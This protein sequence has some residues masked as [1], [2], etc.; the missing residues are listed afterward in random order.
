MA[1]NQHP[2]NTTMINEGVTVPPSGIIGTGGGSLFVIAQ[3]V[4]YTGEGML[5][6]IE[7][8]IEFFLGGRGSLFEIE[9]TV[10]GY[11]VGKLFDIQQTIFSETVY[12]YIALAG[13]YPYIAIDGIIIPAEQITGE[14][15]VT[16]KENESTQ[17]TFTL[18]NPLGVQNLEQY[19]GKA[20]NIVFIYPTTAELVF[21]G[22]VNVITRDFVKKRSTY[23]CSNM[24]REAIINQLGPFVSTIGYYDANVMGAVTDVADE[25]EKR[26]STTTQCVDLDRSG[27]VNIHDMMPKTSPD[28][29]FSSGGLYRDVYPTVDLR[30]RSRVVNSITIKLTYQYVRLYQREINYIWDANYPSVCDFLQQGYSVAAKSTIEAAIQ[31]TGWPLRQIAYEPVLEGGWYNCDGVSMGWV[32]GNFNAG[33]VVRQTDDEGN[34]IEDASGNSIAENITPGSNISSQNYAFGASWIAATRFSQNRQEEY[35]INVT[36]PASIAQYGIVQ[37][38]EQITVASEFDTSN[39]E[40]FQAYA[41][42]PED[43]TEAGPDYWIDADHVEGNE[44]DRYT[45]AQGFLLAYARAKSVILKSHR[46]DYCTFRVPF[47]PAIELYHTIRL[48]A[49]LSVFGGSINIIGKVIQIH[50]NFRIRNPKAAYTEITI[51]GCRSS[52]VVSETPIALPLLLQDNYVSPV[53]AVSMSSMY[54][55]EAPESFYGF[56]GNKFVKE[57]KGTTVDFR[58]TNFTEKFRVKTPEIESQVRNTVTLTASQVYYVDIPNY[59]LTIEY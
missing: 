54:G 52:S 7:Q 6:E 2:I 15:D 41:N 19:E 45:L 12:Q 35:T 50:H 26:L 24:R 39:W 22:V 34:P 56:S 42:P 27:V 29:T 57:R 46:S 3:Y 58:R 13:F 21:T 44:L 20:V 11:G 37:Q 48:N 59:L 49:P 33:D 8:T 30:Q 18:A 51:A 16:A 14:I 25:L 40:N 9:Q 28:I 17:A 32:N 31:G 36:S 1:L 4:A 23:T 53:E 10:Q 47:N 5:F 43:A 38:N 55:A